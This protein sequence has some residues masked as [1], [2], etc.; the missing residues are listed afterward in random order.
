MR[1]DVCQNQ[2]VQFCHHFI[3]SASRK[4]FDVLLSCGVRVQEPA[5]LCSEEPS[6]TGELQE[7]LE[8]LENVENAGA[9]EASDADVVLPQFGQQEVVS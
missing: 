6:S 1:M 9:L 4:S 2:Q 3:H 7:N 5:A 8:N